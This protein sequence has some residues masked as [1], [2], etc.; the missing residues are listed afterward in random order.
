M[1]VASFAVV[2]QKS[3]GLY[4]RMTK[5]DPVTNEPLYGPLAAS[6]IANSVPQAAAQAGFLGEEDHEVVNVR[7]AS[8]DLSSLEGSSPEQVAAI[9]T[10]ANTRIHLEVEVPRQDA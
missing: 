2:R 9:L 10:N 1:S 7:F 8:S 4:L 5:F 3:T 6:W